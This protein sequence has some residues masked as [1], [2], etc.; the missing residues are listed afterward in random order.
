MPKK[1]P[2]R[3]DQW[4]MQ[5]PDNHIEW[6]SDIVAGKL[7]WTTQSGRER[8]QE[9]YDDQLGA[10]GVSPTTATSLKF[11]TRERYT[12]FTDP[13]LVVDDPEEG[14]E[15]EPEVSPVDQLQAY[16]DDAAAHPATVPVDP[17]QVSD[18]DAKTD[19]APLPVVPAGPTSAEVGTPPSALAVAVSTSPDNIVAD[20]NT[21]VLP[22]DEGGPVM[23][24]D[25]SP[26]PATPPVIV[27]VVV[28]APVPPVL[29]ESDEA[30]TA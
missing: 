21:I 7:G 30:T 23:S 26:A 14:A 20:P 28:P 8:V 25:P 10:L 1:N 27:N 18:A 5:T 29:D 4:G 11:W 12:A 24:H 6:H 9:K 16:L 22:A 3:E 2:D 15:G 13:V 17:P 19:T